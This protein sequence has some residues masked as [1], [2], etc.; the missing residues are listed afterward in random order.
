MGPTRK[1]VAPPFFVYF[2]SS[3]IVITPLFAVRAGTVAHES[4]PDPA[5]SLQGNYQETGIDNRVRENWC[6]D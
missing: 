2:E 3:L 5:V 6:G 4:I 1:S